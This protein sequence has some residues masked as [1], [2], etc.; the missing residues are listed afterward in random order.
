[1]ENTYLSEA[2]QMARA[3]QNQDWVKTN[4]QIFVVE[5]CYCYLLLYQ[6]ALTSQ[7]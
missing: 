2:E 5:L 4:I 6:S 3:A 7:L 1:M